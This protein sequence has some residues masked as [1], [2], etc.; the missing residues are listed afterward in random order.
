RWVPYKV[1]A[2]GYEESA[3]RYIV[4]ARRQQRE[5]ELA[6]AEARERRAFADAQAARERSLREKREPVEQLLRKTLDQLALHRFDQ[7]EETIAEILD[8]DPG[9]EEALKFRELAVDARHRRMAETTFDRNEAE[10]VLEREGFT[11]LE[12]TSHPYRYVIFPDKEKWAKI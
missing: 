11:D 5:R 7:A 4:Q 1:D 9:N 8:K 12:V 10:H 3:K 2:E 6:E